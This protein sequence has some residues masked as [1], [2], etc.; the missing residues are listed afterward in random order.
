MQVQ[1][2]VKKISLKERLY[3][4]RKPTKYVKVSMYVKDTSRSFI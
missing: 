3:D 1:F 2:I 4:L